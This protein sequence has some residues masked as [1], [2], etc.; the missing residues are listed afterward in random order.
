MW[1]QALN[2]YIF[3]LLNFTC[4]LNEPSI[5]KHFHFPEQAHVVPGIRDL[6]TLALLSGL[7][8]EITHV[9]ETP[10]L[11]NQKQEGGICL[12]VSEWAPSVFHFLAF[13]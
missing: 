6:S 2:V 1:V 3:N 8:I 12:Y 5:F 7:V 11:T 10:V 13:S 9:H 4:S